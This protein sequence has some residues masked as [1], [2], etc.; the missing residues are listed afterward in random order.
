VKP[1]SIISEETVKIN[2]ECGKAIYMGEVQGSE[3]MNDT[4]VKI[5]RVGMVDRSI[6][7]LII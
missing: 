5:M 2:N 6:T 7:V 3:N 4:R 1:L